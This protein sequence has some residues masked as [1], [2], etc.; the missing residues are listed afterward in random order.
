M[1]TF[2]LK[3]VLFV[4]LFI[5]ALLCLL[6]CLNLY[7]EVDETKTWWKLNATVATASISEQ[8]H[9]KGTTYCALVN[10]TFELD[11][12]QYTYPL[13]TSNRPCRSSLESV[14]RSIATF[15]EGKVI[16]V[17]VDPAKP[18]RVKPGS[19]SLGGAFYL[20][21]VL[22]ALASIGAVAILRSSV[23]NSVRKPARKPARKPVRLTQS[24]SVSQSALSKKEVQKKVRELLGANI[25]K[26][27]VF[28]QLSGQGVKDSQL[29]YFI[30]SYADPVRCDEHDRK[31]NILITIM[32][33][34]A[35]IGFILGMTLGA[36]I[37]PAAKWIVSISMI[38]IPLLWVWGFY[39]HRVVAY[40]A[41]ILLA[42]PQFPTTLA[43]FASNP[44]TTTVS[45][46]ISIVMLAFVWYVRGK[47]FPDFAFVTPRKVKGKYFF[48]D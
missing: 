7:K 40:N 9:S 27:E 45:L 8:V 6:A 14:E 26:S 43:G 29:A 23:R 15:R 28:S 35:L 12:Q 2:L 36:G 11:G 46:V 5:F 44:A 38:L 18:G 16:G 22:G 41:Y 1:K 19:L 31:V 37:G 39:N 4:V 10:V 21:T 32:L 34:Q 42:L 20:V 17:L 3:A 48:T 33:V 13:E 24:E 47:I 30:A 25:A